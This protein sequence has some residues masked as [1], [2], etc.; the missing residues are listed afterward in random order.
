[1]QL[2]TNM[3]SSGDGLL[4]G[5]PEQDSTKLASFLTRV[6]CF[7]HLGEEEVYRE[8]VG[9]N[10]ARSA[11]GSHPLVSESLLIHRVSPQAHDPL[12]DALVV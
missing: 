3:R 5:T 7:G 10:G 6:H 12:V 4:S 8:E 11:S 2:W 1:M 9:G